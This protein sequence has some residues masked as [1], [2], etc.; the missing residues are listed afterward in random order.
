MQEEGMEHQAAEVSG[1]VCTRDGARVREINADLQATAAS[2][3]RSAATVCRL[4]LDVLPTDVRA[5]LDAY[6]ARGATLS[7]E[8]D[9]L[10]PMQPQIHLHLVDLQGTR[11]RVC[12]LPLTAGATPH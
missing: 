4:V 8:V 12:S 7:V 5:Q 6:V 3:F 1:G 2:H 11:Y 10:S 9:V